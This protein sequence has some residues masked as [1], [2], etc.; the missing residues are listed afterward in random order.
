HH[1]S[2]WVCRGQE[3]LARPILHSQADDR[4]LQVV[5]QRRQHQ[6]RWR[7]FHNRLEDVFL[8][9]RHRPVRRN[10]HDRLIAKLEPLPFCE[11][12]SRWAMRGTVSGL[13]A[14]GS[15][16]CGAISCGTESAFRTLHVP[17]SPVGEAWRESGYGVRS[18][19]ETSKEAETTVSV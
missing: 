17:G 15:S 16:G 4:P 10:L 18:M 7:P 3:C 13:Q 2:A 12:S 1:R 19:S 6:G 5:D 8:E 14:T 9:S 11:R